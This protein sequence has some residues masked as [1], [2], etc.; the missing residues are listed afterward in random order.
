M[1]TIALVDDH[2]LYREGLRALLLQ[3]ADF[4]IVG[5]AGDANAACQMVTERNPDVV[6]LDMV[7]PGI[8]GVSVA[9]ELIRR[10]PKRRILFVSM[11][12]T[13]DAVAEG[14]AAGALGYLGKDASAAELMRA[15][16]TV[17]SGQAYLDP[18]VSR[19]GV[20]EFLR[21][22]TKGQ[23][24]TPLDTLSTREREVFRLILKGFTSEGVAGELFISRRTVETHRANLSRK[25]QVKT[26][27]ELFRFAARNDLLTE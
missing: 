14:V 3:E 1:L 12:I 17:A 19:T 18:S 9:R 10:E 24:A 22:R 26:T 23:E 2:T 20:N 21:R 13:E 25:L 5:E 16:R 6:L 4:S 11:K 8:T 7:L 15:V 27:A